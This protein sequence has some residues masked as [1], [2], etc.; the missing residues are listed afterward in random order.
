MLKINRH[1]LGASI[2]LAIALG[3]TGFSMNLFDNNLGTYNEFRVSGH[4]NNPHQIPD[5]LNPRLIR[6]NE[7]LDQNYSVEESSVG[8]VQALHSMV[9][10]KSVAYVNPTL[11]YATGTSN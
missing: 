9:L 8:S 1:I 3:L 11:D 4:L 7:R 6:A 10:D 2:G 5:N